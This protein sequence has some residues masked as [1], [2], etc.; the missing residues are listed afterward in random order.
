MPIKSEES[1][2]AERVRELKDEEERKRQR[3]RQMDRIV[4]QRE[5]RKDG[6]GK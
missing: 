2:R 6:A 5:R 1:T 4:R 3:E